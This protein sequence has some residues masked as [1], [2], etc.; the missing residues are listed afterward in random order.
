MF[1]ARH[2]NEMYVTMGG[3]RQRGT[4]DITMGYDIISLW[5]ITATTPKDLVKQAKTLMNDEI[6]GL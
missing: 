5:N 4:M 3:Y 1:I 2:Q 6:R